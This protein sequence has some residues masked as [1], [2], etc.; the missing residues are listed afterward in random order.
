MPSEDKDYLAADEDEQCLVLANQLALALGE[1]AAKLSSE[2]L[3]EVER[4][5]AVTRSHLRETLNNRLPVHQL[6]AEVMGMIFA[7]ALPCH[8][9]SFRY[10]GFE[11]PDVVGV[12]RA[13]LAISAVCRR[14]RSIACQMASLW[15]VVEVSSSAPWAAEC[16]CRSGNMPLHVLARYPFAN[17]SESTL[18]TQGNRI[19]D[20]FLE[21]LKQ[22]SAR[23]P[24]E[25]PNDLPPVPN[26]ECLVIA[27]RCRPFEDGR[28]MVDLAHRVPLFPHPPLR[29]R[30]L[31]LKN[32][33]WFPA[34]PYDRL[35]HLYIS[36][37]TPIDFRS[38]LTLLGHCTALEKLIMVDVYLAAANQVPADYTVSLPSLRLLTLGIN[39]SRMLMRYLLRA[40]MLPSTA[41]LRIFGR[42]ALRALSGLDPFPS[43][44]FTR[45]FDTLVIDSSPAGCT[46]Q[47][48]G[49]SCGLL[50]DFGKTYSPPVVKLAEHVLLSLIPFSNI[51][52]LTLRGEYS[53]QLVFGSMPSLAYVRLIDGGPEVSLGD[54]HIHD[55]WVGS[56]LEVGIS[57]FPQ[58]SEMDI[59][60]ATPAMTRPIK[61][62]WFPSLEK[63]A[64]YHPALQNALN[65]HLISPEAV[66]ES[67][68]PHAVYQQVDPAEQP[69][70]DL[71]GI[72]PVVH[73][74]EW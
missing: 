70:L 30:M 71:P 56:A 57:R 41:I 26:L 52:S 34:I 3:R 49:P 67:N 44:P 62:S 37:G 43:P 32:Q 68:F 48:S 72:R 27:T 18:I 12:R 69:A 61:P 13:R 11:E 14:W 35:T 19:R 20:L 47:A 36:Q 60:T 6:P 64:V 55:P 21:L 42:E 74:Y 65:Q 8:E 7:S 29:L 4:S 15:G 16:F 31:I 73:A 9:D 2:T 10:S 39:Q 63:V 17:T 23:V 54:L 28:P 53:H 45:N 50:L 33:C 38:L 25:L 1:R 51:R 5:L 40:L 24:V 58:V 22:D 59:W 46:V 66:R